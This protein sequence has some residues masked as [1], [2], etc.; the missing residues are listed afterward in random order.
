[1]TTK[2]LAIWYDTEKVLAKA[3]LAGWKDG[4]DSLLD[5]YSPEEDAKGADVKTFST[6]A[7][8]VAFLAPMCADENKLF[9]RQGTIREFD[10]GGPRCRYC[11]CEGWRVTHEYTVEA[12]GIVETSSRDECCN[13]DD[14]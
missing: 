11:T 14:D 13:G 5:C 4:D 6:L 10:V 9:W 2:W 7:A 1:M 8:A 12:E 3:R